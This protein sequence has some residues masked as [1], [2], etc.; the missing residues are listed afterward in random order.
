[1]AILAAVAGY[2]GVRAIAD[3]ADGEQGASAAH[4]IVPDDVSAPNA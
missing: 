2:F 4:A 3:A 1:M